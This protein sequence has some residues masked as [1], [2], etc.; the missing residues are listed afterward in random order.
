MM[1]GAGYRMGLTALLL[2]TGG[3]LGENSVVSELTE[4]DRASPCQPFR[5]NHGTVTCLVSKLSFRFPL[6]S[7]NARSLTVPA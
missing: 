4:R 2:G 6:V 3:L 7:A 1:V 5:E